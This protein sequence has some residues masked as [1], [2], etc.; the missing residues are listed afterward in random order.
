M[1]LYINF[2]LI[3][4]DGCC[5]VEIVLEQLCAKEEDCKAIGFYLLKSDGTL[6]PAALS[7]KTASS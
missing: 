3:L 6:P 5:R 7:C 1:E 2:L 4:I